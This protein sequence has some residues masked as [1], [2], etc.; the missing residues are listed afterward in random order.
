MY[1]EHVFCFKYQTE[2]AQ[3]H[4]GVYVVTTDTEFSDVIAP[5][6]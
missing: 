2:L 3:Q 4:S 1:L 5:Y 6:L